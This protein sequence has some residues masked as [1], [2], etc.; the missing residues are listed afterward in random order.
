LAA[1]PPQAPSRTRKRWLA[2][3]QERTLAATSAAAIIAGLLIA[4]V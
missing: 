1:A 2:D 4:L 3:L